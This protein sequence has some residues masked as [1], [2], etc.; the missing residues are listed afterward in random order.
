MKIITQIRSALGILA[1]I[2]CANIYFSLFSHGNGPFAIGASIIALTLLIYLQFMT[3]RRMENPLELISQ[4]AE[5]VAQGD[6][7]FTAAYGAKDEFGDIARNFETIRGS[8]RGIVEATVAS[9]NEIISHVDAMIFRSEQTANSAQEQS[10][11]AQQVAAAAEEMSQTIADIAQ[12]AANASETSSQALAVARHGN[13]VAQSS[14]ATVQRVHAATNTLASMIERLNQSVGE[15]SGI[16][17]VIKSIADQTNLLALNAAIEAARAGEHGRGFTVVADEVRKLA[18][19]TIKATEEISSRIATV[20]SESQQTTQSMAAASQEVVRATTDIAKV[21]E[22][23]G[24]IVESV[25]QVRDQIAQ[26]ATSVEQQSHTTEEVASN[27][28]QTAAIAR[29]IERM[30]TDIKNDVNDIIG[31]TL[32]SRDAADKYKVDSQ[33]EQIL[34]RAKSDH[35]IFMYKIQGHLSKAMHLEVD[36]LPDHHSCRF[37]KWYHSLGLRHH[38]QMA[39]FRS[40]DPPHARL[41]SLAKEVVSA[42]NA[43]NLGKAQEIYRDMARLSAEIVMHLDAV[44]E[45]TMS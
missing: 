18:E 11:Q 25:Q 28:E 13:E 16:V 43:G 45:E 12:N 26:I 27:I 42:A 44:K 40:I 30:S 10:G 5:K 39:S 15:I 37:G 31:I 17:E 41:H 9:T 36:T 34:D 6:M 29:N 20:Q 21:S 22:A 1:L 35:I 23:L 38:S 7:T 2:S 3:H 19:R 4:S 33:L 8:L 24:S 32:K 14:G